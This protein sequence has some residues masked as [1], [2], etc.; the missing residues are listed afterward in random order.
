MRA[1]QIDVWRGTM[2]PLF[3]REVAPRIDPG[4]GAEVF[5]QASEQL[6]TVRHLHALFD[7][8]FVE[9]RIPRN[10]AV[11]VLWSDIRFC[12]PTGCA[13][14]FGGT[15][16]RSTGAL[17]EQVVLVGSLRQTRAP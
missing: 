13:L 11:D 3:S 6:D 12:W 8:T 7:L 5:I 14:W 9:L 10:D 16:D 15:F 1:F 2:R 17:R 4:T